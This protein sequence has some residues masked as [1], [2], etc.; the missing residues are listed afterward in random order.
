[1]AGGYAGTGNINADPLFVD[2]ATGDLHILAGSP[3]VD[4][5]NTAAIPAGLVTDLDGNARVF[6]AAVDMGAYEDATPSP[7]S[8]AAILAAD[9]TSASGSYRIDP[10]GPEF[11]V[12]PFYAYCDMTTDGGGW[13][14]VAAI[15]GADGQ[16]TLV[17]DVEVAGNPLAF[18]H[19]NVNRAKKVALSAISVESI[20]VR[21]SGVWL[22][23][24]APLFDENL[25]TPNMHSHFDVGFE[26]SGGATAT[27]YMGYSNYNISGG[28]DFNAG[29]SPADHHSTNYYHLNSGCTGQYLYS[30]SA[31]AMDGDPGYDANTA[32]GAWT[33]T[34]GCNGA[35]GGAL[36]FYA[37]MR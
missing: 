24:D 10:D 31:T 1:V 14:I 36:V 26:A 5:G 18:A 7:T 12:V 11:G 27:G 34:D 8:C 30:Y 23:A 13:T 9:D 33:A 32:L 21:S 28:G 25:S 35:E 16:Q 3:C 2:A 37:A 29:P 22:E 20:F 4:A 19:Y 15:T 6:G 17:S